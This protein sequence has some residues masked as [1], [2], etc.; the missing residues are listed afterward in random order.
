MDKIYS[1]YVV[2]DKDRLVGRVSLKKVI[3][4]DDKAIVGDIYDEDGHVGGC[5]Y[6]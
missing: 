1:V 6:A 5:F 2:D 3:I 4:S